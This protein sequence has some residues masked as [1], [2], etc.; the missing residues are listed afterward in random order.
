MKG[1]IAQPDDHASLIYCLR[2][3]LSMGKDELIN[4]LAFGSCFY[5]FLW[6]YFVVST[7]M[8]GFSLC[9]LGCL[10]DSKFSSSLLCLKTPGYCGSQAPSK[11]VASIV[12][13]AC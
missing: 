4:K 13:V 2:C 9:F 7:F 1:R 8:P 6:F 5:S 12:K 10:V 11:E 3:H